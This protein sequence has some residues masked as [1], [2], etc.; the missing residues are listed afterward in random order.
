MTFNR[1][2]CFCNA[3]LKERP[4]KIKIYNWGTDAGGLGVWGQHSRPPGMHSKTHHK[5]LLDSICLKL[6][7]LE[8]H[9]P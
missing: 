3:E 2:Y 6:K 8:V 5:G 1:I 7:Q 9:K 4:K